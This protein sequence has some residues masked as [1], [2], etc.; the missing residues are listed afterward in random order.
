[1]SRGGFPRGGCVRTGLHAQEA[2]PGIVG[3][4]IAETSQKA[5][6]ET[7]EIGVRGVEV[8][9]PFADDA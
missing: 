2:G 1:M 4:A 6:Q 3:T 9:R 5:Q 8:L 7:N